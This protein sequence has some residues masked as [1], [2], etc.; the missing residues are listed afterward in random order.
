MAVQLNIIHR[1][2]LDGPHRRVIPEGLFSRAYGLA[3][4]I[5]LQDGPLFRVLGECQRTVANQVDRGLVS[6]RQQQHDVVDRHVPIEHA[7][8]LTFAD[9]GHQVGAVE[10]LGIVDPILDH[11]RDEVLEV[12][13]RLGQRLHP[14]RPLAVEE[15]QVLGEFAQSLPLAVGY[16]KHPGDDQQGQRGGQVGHDVHPTLF[17]DGVQQFVD[18]GLHQGAPH[19]DRLG[20]EVA[21]HHPAHVDVV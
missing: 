7:L 6:G 8:P 5:G 12:S 1:D 19:F 21:V 18:G 14:V 20:R 11:R 3:F 4:R 16:A 2:A 9:Y 10:I 13:H 17:F 15:P